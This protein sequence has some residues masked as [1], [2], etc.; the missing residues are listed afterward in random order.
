MD[1]L[2]RVMLRIWLRDVVA[3]CA[4]GLAVMAAIVLPGSGDGLGMTRL[5]IGC[6]TLILFPAAAAWFSLRRARRDA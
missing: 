4:L 1:D 5:L 3:P 6:S 2:A